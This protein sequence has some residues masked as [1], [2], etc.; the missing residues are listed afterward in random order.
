MSEKSGAGIK[1]PA[2][3]KKARE[4]EV[5]EMILIRE[6]KKLK[7]AEYWKMD[8]EGKNRRKISYESACRI[9]GSA[10]EENKIESYRT[11]CGNYVCICRIK[12]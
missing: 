6:G 9:E 8:N 5:K 2:P 11:L 12:D 1:P 10:L 4:R 3:H 7:T